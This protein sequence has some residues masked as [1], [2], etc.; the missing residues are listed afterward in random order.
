MINQMIYWILCS[1]HNLEFAIQAFAFFFIVHTV[2]MLQLTSSP[3]ADKATIGIAGSEY[4][5]LELHVIVVKHFPSPI[6]I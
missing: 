2:I 6:P 1:A 4:Y 3:F 5:R